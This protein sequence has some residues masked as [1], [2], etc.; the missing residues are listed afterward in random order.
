MTQIKAHDAADIANAV[1]VHEV[2]NY[3]V[4]VLLILVLITL[5]IVGLELVNVVVKGD[6]WA[7]P[8]LFAVITGGSFVI[9]LIPDLWLSSDV[10]EEKD[11]KI[12]Q[13]SRKEVWILALELALIY[14]GYNA[15]VLQALQYTTPS[16][17]T[18]FGTTSTA[19]CLIIGGVL[20]L[21]KFLTKKVGCVVGL[22]IGVVL[23]NHSA[24]VSDGG[25]KY[26]PTNPVL[27]NTFAL[28]GALLYSIYLILLKVKCGEDATTNERRLFG[29]VGI[30]TIILG[31]PFLL[32]LDYLG[33]EKLEYPPN[34]LALAA[35]II[36][37]VCQVV[38][39]FL[40]V[41]AMLVTSPLVVSLLLTLAIP[42]TILIDYIVI[43]WTNHHLL[44][45]SKAYIVGVVCMLLAVVL[46]NIN[47]TLENELI[48]D[49]IDQTLEEAVVVLGA[50]RAP[51]KLPF[52]PLFRPQH[53][54][55][56]FRHGLSPFAAPRAPAQLISDFNLNDDNVTDHSAIF[57]PNHARLYTLSR[58][59]LDPGLWI[60][61]GRNHHYQ[62]TKVE[63][64]SD[65]DSS[66]S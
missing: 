29:F 15:C 63:E 21:E 61:G 49:I 7:K 5:W 56:G 33:V 28:G 6:L 35:V 46:I 37:G 31:I 60:K 45:F 41:L 48:N 4:G 9:N 32:L 10:E 3:R 20:G 34:K 30:I 13:L 2:S 27:G 54:Q 14:F 22:L 18:V 50:E 66:R 53:V 17:Q 62:L 52:L 16:N 59:L 12:R 11:P 38:S 64:I 65:G 24:Q 25:S 1:N 39:D 36:N 26:E 23:V 8:W 47:I 43:S 44:S 19:F 40:A 51:T 58:T 57:N 42:I 55:T